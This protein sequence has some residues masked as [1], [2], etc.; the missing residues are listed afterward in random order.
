[1]TSA[2]T[3]CRSCSS[4]TSRTTTSRGGEEGTGADY[5]DPNAIGNGGGRR[6]PLWY[7]HNPDDV[8][9]FEKQM[10]RKAHYVI[11]PEYLW[12]SIAHWLA[13]RTRAA[14]TLQAGFK[15]IENESF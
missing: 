15:Y 7:E 13:R 6:C 12:A 2:I 4:A 11:K 8:A 3:C 14:H 10:R 1:M 5:P 9:A